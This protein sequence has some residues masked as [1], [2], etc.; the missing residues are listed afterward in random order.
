VPWRWRRRR[1]Y[2][3]YFVPH[4]ELRRYVFPA[5]GGYP[6]PGAG[7]ENDS[8][9]NVGGPMSGDDRRSPSGRPLGRIALTR[10]YV[11]PFR[12][13]MP[14]ADYWAL[15]RHADAT[16]RTLDVLA[17]DALAS[18]MSAE[19]PPRP[20]LRLSWTL[21]EQDAALLAVVQGRT[22]LDAFGAIRRALERLLEEPDRRV[23]PAAL[24]AMRGEALGNVA[25]V[26]D[27]ET[28]CVDVED[29]SDGKEQTA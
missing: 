2:T 19:G 25:P 22:G 24:A 5:H 21:D 27:G 12:V 7:L 20:G 1:A 6:R 9:L 10:Q 11:V 3:V 18:L 13:P 4:T 17:G 15:R 8:C 16:C 14:E 28:M 26:D 23:S 29:F